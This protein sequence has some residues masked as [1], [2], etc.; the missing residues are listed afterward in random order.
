MIDIPGTTTERFSI[1]FDYEFKVGDVLE[2]NK[3]ILKV[4]RI[5]YEGILG[6]EYKV[7]TVLRDPKELKIAMDHYNFLRKYNL[8]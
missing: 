4:E 6:I 8:V 3:T 2:S 1:L 5:S 7:A